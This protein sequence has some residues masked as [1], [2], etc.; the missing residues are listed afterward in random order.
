MSFQPPLAEDE[1]VLFSDTDDKSLSVVLESATS[2]FDSERCSETF[3]SDT[4]EVLAVTSLFAPVVILVSASV[5]TSFPLEESSPRAVSEFSN[6]DSTLFS[7]G[8]TSLSSVVALLESV[9][10]FPSPITVSPTVSSVLVLP[11][12]AVTKA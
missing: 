2:V 8:K 12:S 7:E 11:L 9:V 4:P 10:S 1:T 6:E 3:G 5:D